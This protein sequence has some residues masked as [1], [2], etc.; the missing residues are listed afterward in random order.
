M[1]HLSSSH[2]ASTLK[3]GV[4]GGRRASSWGQRWAFIYPTPDS[5]LMRYR[6]WKERDSHSCIVNSCHTCSSMFFVCVGV[7]LFGGLTV[8]KH[9]FREGVGPDRGSFGFLSCKQ[10]SAPYT[11]ICTSRF[12]PTRGIGS[13][14]SWK[15][16][17][18]AY[19]LRK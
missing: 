6:C 16:M 19:S 1:V 10:K 9:F 3:S 2:D 18:V 7:W 13:F 14:A 15:R 5:K 4:R 12:R 11:A 8:G 17:A